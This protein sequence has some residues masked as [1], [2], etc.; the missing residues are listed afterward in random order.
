MCETNLDLIDTESIH[1]GH[2]ARQSGLSCSAHTDQQEMALRLPEDSGQT[3]LKSDSTKIMFELKIVIY[4][5]F[6]FFDSPVNSEDM[7]QD[8]VEKYQRH[9]QLFLIENLQT[10]LHVVSQLLLLH[11]DVVLHP[12]PK[13]R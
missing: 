3:I 9:I 8:L 2:K 5:C 1:P 7:V 13:K 12:P 11:W 4:D 6:V 10:R